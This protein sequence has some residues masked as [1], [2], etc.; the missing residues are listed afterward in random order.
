MCVYVCV[1]VCMCVY[2]C[3]CVCM[4]VYV[5]VCV[6]MCVYGPST[7]GAYIKFQRSL[8]LKEVMHIIAALI[9]KK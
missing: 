2:M 3:V 1:C 6:C 4:C 7:V 5:C 8:F 9:F